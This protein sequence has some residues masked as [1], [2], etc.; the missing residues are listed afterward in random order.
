MVVAGYGYCG[1]GIALRAKGMGARVIITEIDPF[2]ALE[3]T[4]ENFT[5]MPMDEAAAV[6]DIFITAT[7]CRDVITSQHFAKMKNHAIL[8][9]AGHFDIEVDRKALSEQA[10]KRD[11]L[12]DNIEGF[13]LADNR[14]L[15]ILAE[16]RLVNLAA[17]NGHPAEIMDMSFAVQTLSLLWMLENGKDL[18]NKVYDVTEAIDNRVAELRLRAAGISIDTLTEEQKKYLY[19]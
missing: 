8:A 6:G 11:L 17:G 7:G 4:M 19:G 1:R 12:R 3:A 14:M 18:E 13:T 16:G 15:I 9:N 5:V 10:V 2:K